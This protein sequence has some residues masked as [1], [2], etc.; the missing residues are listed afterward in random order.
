M[1]KSVKKNTTQR[2]VAIAMSGGV[3][4]S[5]VARMLRDKGYDC[6]G[7]FMRLGIERGC[8]D[9]A[10]ARRVCTKLGIKFYPVDVRV[11]FRKEV[12]DYFLKAYEKGITPNPCVAC[13]KFIKFGELLK[14]AGDLGC[15]YLATGHYIKIKKIGSTYKLYKAKD[16]SKDQSYF[17]Y[18]LTQN[19]LSKI[20][21]PLGDSL[22]EKLKN[23]ATKDDLPFLKKES[24]DIC[25]L[26]GDHNEF[27]KNNLKLK[28]GVIKTLDGEVVGE[29]QGLPLYT[30]G[31]RKG[32][33]IGGKGPYYV[34]RGDTKTNTLYVTNKPD[35]ESLYGKSVE[36][37]NINWISGKTPKSPF[38]CSTVIRY[39]HK[40][41]PCTVYSKEN[42]EITVKF[43]NAQRAITPGQSI[44]F[45]KNDELL[46]GAIIK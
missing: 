19:D 10:A 41:V 9:E 20:L 3:D 28:K 6:V 23:K 14:K 21:F 30:I 13:N 42:G 33:E 2:R 12:K 5:T 27:L 38:K 11:K 45:Y 7:V 1:L 8:C 43:L 32:V 24:Q 46:G 44:V 17:L 37:E 39:R 15:D 26:A 31:Q 29:H 35:E 25:F 4:S 18:N 34:V 16:S 36:A 40:P 22:K